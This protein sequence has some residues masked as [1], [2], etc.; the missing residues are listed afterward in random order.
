MNLFNTFLGD[1][2]GICDNSEEVRERML[3]VDWPF[4]RELLW[5]GAGGGGKR[6]L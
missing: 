1:G 6:G 5:A 3:S 4:T 2:V